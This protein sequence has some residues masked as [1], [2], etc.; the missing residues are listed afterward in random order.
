M[1][2]R[3]TH[4]ARSDGHFD[5]S[6]GRRISE[7]AKLWC[8]RIH[9]MVSHG[10]TESRRSGLGRHTNRSSDTLFVITEPK[11]HKHRSRSHHSVPLRLCEKPLLWE[12]MTTISL[13]SLSPEVGNG[14]QPSG[15]LVRERRPGSQSKT[16]DLPC[17][18]NGTG[19][20]Q[21]PASSV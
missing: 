20:T 15:K 10:D 19:D 18:G 21:F 12:D 2:H 3:G 9:F 5:W 4:E 17:Q 11:L 7:W 1:D 14:Y 13:P 16:T 6:G 8:D